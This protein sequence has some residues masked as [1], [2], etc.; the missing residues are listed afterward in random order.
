[1]EEQSKL[2][3][4][5]NKINN[6]DFEGFKGN[7]MNLFMAICFSIGNRGTSRIEL[8]YN[9]IMKLSRYRHISLDEFHETLKKPFRQK[10]FSLSFGIDTDDE[11]E[12]WVLFDHYSANKKKQ[13]LTLEVSTKAEKF[14][15]NVIKNFT[16][17]DL[18]IYGGL[19]RKYSKFLYQHLCQFRDKTGRGWWQV[20][21][22]ELKHLLNTP[23]HYTNTEI[24]KEVINP[25]IE[26]LKP[27]IAITCDTI[28]ERGKVRAYKFT[29]QEV[30]QNYIE[31]KA[32]VTEDKTEVISKTIEE[33]H[34]S[35]IDEDIIINNLKK[36]CNKLTTRDC[37]AIIDD[38][39]KYSRSETDV[40][41]IVE[42]SIN[43]NT[44]NLVGYIRN[45]LKKGISNKIKNVKK[46]SFHFENERDYNSDDLKELEKKLVSN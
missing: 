5:D 32:I 43:Q 38:M 33:Q 3:K 31:P 8:K 27:F 45:L 13:I 35:A 16:L 24:K 11:Y 34:Q 40:Y 14:F 44:D 2:V 29:F 30:R 1:M 23:T 10:L 28:K 17:F 15:N 4:Y 25:S 36:A 7:D 46:S 37:L 9:E 26:E 12:G 22:D 41:K 19:Q 6:L 20:S 18:S 39:Q 42:Y 21:I